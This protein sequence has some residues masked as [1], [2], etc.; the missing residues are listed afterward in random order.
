MEKPWINSWPSGVPRQMEFRRGERPLFEYLRE[1]ARNFPDKDAIIFYGRKITYRELDDLSDRFAAF[2]HQN[3]VQKGD[4]VALFLPN[5][6][7]YIICHYGIQKAGAV[8]GPCSPMFKEWELEYEVKDMEAETLVTLDLLYPVA[9]AIRGQTGLKRV[10]IT[11]YRDFLPEQPALPLPDE[12]KLPGR[13]YQ[14]TVELK[15]ILNSYPAAPPPVD[16]KIE[17]ISLMVY[18]SGTTG[19][20]K[21]AMLTHYSALFKTACSAEICRS[22]RDEISLSVMPLY[23][24]AGMLMG[25]NSFVYFGG[26]LVLLARFDPLAVVEAIEK[27]K[28]T[29][30][31]SATPMNIGVMQLP[32]IQ[33]RDFKSLRLN[34]CTSFGIALTGEIAAAWKKIAPGCDI[35]EG[36][37]GLS[38]THTLD[39]FMPWD[40]VKYGSTGIPVYD[41]EMKIV[42]PDN[43]S[44]ELPAGSQGEILLKSP[45]LFRGYWKNPVATAGALRDGWL[46]TGDIGK[47]DQDG[48]LYLL[49]RKK[50]MIK[51]SGYSV[52]PEEVETF[53][54]RHPAVAQAAVIGVQDV[55]RSETV[56][57]FIVLKKDNEGKISENDIIEWSKQHMAAYKYPRQVEFRKSL[58]ATATGKVLR[59]VLA[60]EEANK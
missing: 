35:Y 47:F 17:D 25:V 58:P 22:S 21:G 20:P 38:E 2:L 54:L 16:I 26:T 5:C 28:V 29:F 7:Q 37:Y 42:D 40:R 50:E 49:G 57:A 51:C 44:L 13:Q 53:L 4:R 43:P 30:W 27:Y 32:D 60:E 11:G 56:K 14:D 48:Y 12:L 52:F 24:I 18:T 15:D 1:N 34:L 46:H 39:T 6:P 59:R 19:L 3:G 41:T 23:H 55:K 10:V 9:E 8:A 33:K 45:A 31:Y 36:A